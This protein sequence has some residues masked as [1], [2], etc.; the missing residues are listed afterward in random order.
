M[1][2]DRERAQRHPML[3]PVGAI[4]FRIRKLAL[5]LFPHC[6]T[7]K[8]IISA[9]KLI[10]S[11]N[12]L[13]TAGLAFA[14]A[15][16][17]RARERVNFEI[18]EWMEW[19]KAHYNPFAAMY[20]WHTRHNTMAIRAWMLKQHISINSHKWHF[21]KWIITFNYNLSTMRGT[22]TERERL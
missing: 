15:H 10:L 9:I 1:R 3:F 11:N 17:S 2:Y 21:I 5:I 7:N 6:H 8:L 13:Q 20:W 22:H 12:K 19:K 14:I 4:S 16:K 18:M